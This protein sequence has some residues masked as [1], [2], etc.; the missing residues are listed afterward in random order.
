MALHR[1]LTQLDEFD[2]I[3]DPFAGV[4]DIDW[5]QVLSTPAD[6]QSVTPSRPST[7]EYFP[8]DP[9]DESFLAQL[10]MLQGMDPAFSDTV[11]PSTP[12]GQHTV[13]PDVLP[14]VLTPPRVRSKRSWGDSQ[15]WALTPSRKSDTSSL[16]ASDSRRKRWQGVDPSRLILAGFEGELTCPICCDIF[17]GTHMG[18]CG[19]SFCGD[20]AWQWLAKNKLITGCPIC[21]TPLMRMV[22][23]LSMD[24]M[25]DLHIQ[26]LSRGYTGDAGWKTLGPKLTEFLGRQKKWKD[27]AAERGKEPLST[28]AVWLAPDGEDARQSSG[29]YYDNISSSLS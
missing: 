25:V 11:P 23:N 18:S 12:D 19:H 16:P 27:G 20:C 21:R 24:K 3:P 29:D 17:V 1:T 10:D 14:T 8:D 22:P 13:P 4:H 28:A 5:A 26:M 9:V 6:T 7:P 2:A 15:E